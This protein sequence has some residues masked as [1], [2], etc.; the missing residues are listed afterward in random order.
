VFQGSR[1]S[2]AWD[3]YERTDLER[4]QSLADEYEEDPKAS[5]NGSFH[6]TMKPPSRRFWDQGCAPRFPEL[7][8]P[9]RRNLYGIGCRMAGA[10]CP[11]V[12]Q[13]EY[14]TSIGARVLLAAE[15]VSHAEL[16]ASTKRREMK[17]IRASL[18]TA[19]GPSQN[20]PGLSDFRR[21]RRAVTPNS[22]IGR[23]KRFTQNVE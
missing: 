18:I 22:S 15:K 9:K 2:A 19:V 20:L 16:T 10:A 1:R 3:H 7:G 11:R 23:F 5:D 17:L 12:N 4:T 8:D 6:S 14:L 21:L 13:Y